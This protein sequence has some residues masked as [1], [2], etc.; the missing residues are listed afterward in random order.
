MKTLLI[1]L[2]CYNEEQVLEKTVFTLNEYAS[3][4]LGNYDWKILIIDNNSQDKTGEIARKLRESAPERI[5]VSSIP[6]P[7]RGI[8]VR[9]TWLSMPGYDIYSYMDTDLATDIKDYHFIVKKVDEGY[10]LVTGSRYL[11]HS[12]ADRTFKRK[13]LSKTYNMLLKTVLKVDFM[14]AQ[15]GFKAMSGNMV[16][17]VFPRTYDNG[18]FWDAETMILACRGPYR[19]LEVPV[20]WKEVRDELRASKVSVWSEVW[21]NLGNIYRMRRRLSNE[22]GR[23]TS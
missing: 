4:N 6:T 16:K 12:N 10:D 1:T 2:P 5:L 7:G 22:H 3:K 21:K 19:V 14:D 17:E 15:C 20:T 18:W 9:S 23:T 13:F 11:P 8:A